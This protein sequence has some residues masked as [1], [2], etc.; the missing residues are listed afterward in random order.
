M[1]TYYSDHFVEQDSTDTVGMSSPDPGYKAAPGIGHGRKRYKRM[2]VNVPDQAA[3]G[4]KMIL[5]S[6]R[7]SDRIIEMHRQADDLSVGAATVDL[8]FYYSGTNHDG[9]ELDKDV[10]ENGQSVAAAIARG[11]V[12]TDASLTDL[13]RGTPIWA[14]C[15]L[16]ADPVKQ[17]DLVLEVAT[18]PVDLGGTYVCEVEYTSGD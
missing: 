18:G 4:D 14:I 2:Q 17:V 16:S 5:G 15:G 7:S 10:I 3:A 9:A 13:D 11:E 12:F 1:A 8:G 6:F